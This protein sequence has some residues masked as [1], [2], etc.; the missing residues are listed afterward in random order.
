M[1]NANYKKANKILFYAS[2]LLT[3]LSGTQFEII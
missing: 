2:I 1:N 3:A